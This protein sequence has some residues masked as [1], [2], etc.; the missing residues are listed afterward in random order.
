MILVHIGTRDVRSEI[1]DDKLICALIR[2][3][4]IFNRFATTD[5]PYSSNQ[6]VFIWLIVS[7]R[8]STKL[9][10]QYKNATYV[11]SPAF[12][13]MGAKCWGHNKKKKSRIL[14]KLDVLDKCAE[15]T[16]LSPYEIDLKTGLSAS[17]A[18]I[19]REEEIKW[20]QRSNARASSSSERET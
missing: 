12:E 14:E 13:R 5:V 20:N 3:V 11:T 4:L 1:D 18:N 10:S 16:H 8:S 17:L 7:T 2:Y 6:I 19:L 9:Y 15:N